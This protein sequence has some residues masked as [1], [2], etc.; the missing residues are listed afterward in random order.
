MVLKGR[1]I[2]PDRIMIVV[3]KWNMKWRLRGGRV[4]RPETDSS[5]IDFINGGSKF[6]VGVENGGRFIG[7]TKKNT[8]YDRCGRAI[9]PEYSIEAIT[10]CCESELYKNNKILLLLHSGGDDRLSENQS[11]FAALEKKKNIVI[12]S[13][14]GGDGS[15]YENIID[16]TKTYFRTDAVENPT[17]K[18]NFKIKKEKFDN[19]WNDY[20]IKKK[21]NQLIKMLLPIAIDCQGL[22]EVDEE[23]EDEY[24]N[25]IMN[26]YKNT[27]SSINELENRI[28]EI[29]IEEDNKSYYLELFNE[30]K[31]LNLKNKKIFINKYCDNRKTDTFFPTKFEELIKKINIII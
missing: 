20:F 24:F 22:S 29:K 10:D 28:G 7:F 26:A 8:I 17:N 14:S 3:W 4:C 30:L 18:N 23:F 19:V 16:G 13:F 2:M 25:K 15:I 31:N 5:I 27:V 9:T 1:S 12:E 6:E 21:R 11:E